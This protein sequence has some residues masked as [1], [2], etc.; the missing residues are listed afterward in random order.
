MGSS[1]E[2]LREGGVIGRGRCHHPED[3]VPQ[4]EQ[5]SFGRPDVQGGE[6]PYGEHLAGH[7]HGE[8]GLLHQRG[9]AALGRLAQQ[10]ILPLAQ[11]V[12]HQGDIGPSSYEVL[13]G[14]IL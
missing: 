6:L 8:E 7:P 1:E 12:S 2:L 14:H 9:F 5:E 3:S 4:P 10:D 13:A 11:K